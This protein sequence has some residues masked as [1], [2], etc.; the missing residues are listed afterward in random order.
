MFDLSLSLPLGVNIHI[1]VQKREQTGFQ[2]L[3][4]TL[5]WVLRYTP[6]YPSKT[7][8]VLGSETLDPKVSEM[9]CGSVLL[10]STVQYI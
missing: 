2:E 10:Y 8:K 1:L 9:H 3:P 6:R 5:P 7:H 4:Q